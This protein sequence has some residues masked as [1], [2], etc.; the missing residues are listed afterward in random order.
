MPGK[1]HVGAAA[2][3]LP[4]LTEGFLKR[5]AFAV[6]RQYAFYA[7]IC[8]VHG[9]AVSIKGLDAKLLAVCAVLVEQQPKE[10]I[11]Y[12]CLSCSVLTINGG[13]AIGVK[14][15]FKVFYPLEVG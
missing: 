11:H 6:N 10:S 13:G 15:H 5:K 9:L 4:L 2:F 14:L 3:L 8:P 1:L 12:G 7:V